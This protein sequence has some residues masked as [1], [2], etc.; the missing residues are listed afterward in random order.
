MSILILSEFRHYL[1]TVSCA[2]ACACA[3]DQG[4]PHGCAPPR[5]RGRSTWWWTLRA[6]TR[7]RS[8][9]TLCFQGARHAQRRA[10]SPSADSAAGSDARSSTLT[11]WMCQSSTR[12]VPPPAPACVSQGVVAL[13]AAVQV[14][15]NQNLV[16]VRLDEKGECAQPHL[17]VRGS[18]S[19]PSRCRQRTGVRAPCSGEHHLTTARTC[20]C[21]LCLACARLVAH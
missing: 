8:T 10:C 17:H 5:R 12:H 2:A 3:R 16:K 18:Y 11:R 15:V 20:F 1:A 21:S 14:N 9:L 4:S 13:T 6:T 7:C 19:C